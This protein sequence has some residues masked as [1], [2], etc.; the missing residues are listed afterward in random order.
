MLRTNFARFYD[1]TTLTNAVF[2]FDKFSY[3]PW[4]MKSITVAESKCEA[5]PVT[6]TPFKFGNET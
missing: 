6:S 2:H 5:S 4:K 1:P 3:S